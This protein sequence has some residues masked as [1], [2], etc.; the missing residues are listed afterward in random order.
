[1][2]NTISQNWYFS[3]WFWWQIHVAIPVVS[4][5]KAKKQHYQFH[6]VFWLCGAKYICTGCKNSKECQVLT[7]LVN[8]SGG[9]KIRLLDA[10]SYTLWI[11]GKISFAELTRAA[12][13]IYSH[14]E[15]VAKPKFALWTWI[16]LPLPLHVHFVC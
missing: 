3:S 1:M 8:L 11:S 4:A 7:P 5:S 2:A 16:Q 6:N 14:C 10:L 9:K 15:F 13:E 12:S